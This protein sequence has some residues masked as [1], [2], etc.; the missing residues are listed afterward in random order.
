MAWPANP[1]WDY[2]VELY[3][4]PGVEAACLELQ[5]RHGVDV[6]LVL[7][8]C[9]QATRGAELDPAALSRAKTAVASWQAEVVRPLRAL[10]QRLRA[11]LV[12]P[13]PGSVVELWP[14]LAAALRERALD[15]EIDGER[16]AQLGLYR[17]ASGLAAPAAPG[18]ALASANLRRYWEFD[19]RDRHALGILLGNAFPEAGP[20][21]LEASLDW[22][23][24]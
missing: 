11:R 2:A 7:L 8:C 19:R 14:D 16:L 3:G 12:D 17:A 23:E 22:L 4:R 18:P 10:R 6:N 5:R 24:A 21:E 20:D 9:W 1:L 15:L 13:E